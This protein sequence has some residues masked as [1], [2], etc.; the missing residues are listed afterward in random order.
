MAANFNGYIGI[1]A[2]VVSDHGWFIAFAALT[3]APLR[4]T[5]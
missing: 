1:M 2:N 3:Q 5:R 4:K